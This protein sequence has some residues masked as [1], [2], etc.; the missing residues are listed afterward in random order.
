[1]STFSELVIGQI[2]TYVDNNKK[3]PTK[4]GTSCSKK[5][6]LIRGKVLHSQGISKNEEVFLKKLNFVLS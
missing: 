4:M 6:M 3:N 5:L 1:M 2:D